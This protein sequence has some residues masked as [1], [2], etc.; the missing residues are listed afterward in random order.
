MKSYPDD[1]CFR[2]RSSLTDEEYKFLYG[3][4]KPIIIKSCPYCGIH[5]EKVG[6]C[7]HMHCTNCETRFS[8]ETL[9]IYAES[10]DNDSDDSDD[11]SDSDS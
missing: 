2:C 6:G 11:S 8:W 9:Q 4:N 5:I 7:D 1:R 3:N 10:E